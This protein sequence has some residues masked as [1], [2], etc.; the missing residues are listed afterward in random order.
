MGSLFNKDGIAT[1]DDTFHFKI[2]SN[3][4]CS[5]FPCFTDYY[6]TKLKDRLY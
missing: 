5:R 6:E 4:L 1:A 2:K 3:E